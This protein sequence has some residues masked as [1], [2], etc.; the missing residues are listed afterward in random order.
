M[1]PTMAPRT[2]QAM[3]PIAGLHDPL[4]T[5]SVNGLSEIAGL[6]LL[7]ELTR[8]LPIGLVR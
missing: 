4:L 8:Y 6:H 2:I 3:M 7:P 5:V 1:M